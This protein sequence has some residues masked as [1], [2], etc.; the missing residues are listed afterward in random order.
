MKFKFI[1][2]VFLTAIANIFGQQNL[3]SQPNTPPLGAGGPYSVNDIINKI[4]SEVGIDWMKETR[5][6][7]IAGDPNTKVTGIATTFMSTLAVL[8][9][10][11]AMGCNFVI[12]HEPT[13]YTHTDDLKTHEKDPVQIAKLKF[14]NDNKMV[15]WRFHDHQHRMPSGDQIYQGVVEKMGW[16]KYATSDKTLLTIPPKSLAE[17]VKT[18]EKN[19]GAKTARIVGKPNMMVTKVGLALGA[20]G[21]GTHFNVM[22]TTSCELLIVGES[23][24]WETIPY[25]QDA[26]NLGLKRSIIVLGHADSEEAGMLTNR[27]WLRGFYPNLKIEFIEAGNPYWRN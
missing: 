1:L 22:E 13:F 8:K 7:V 24:E 27:N 21:T 25:I 17:I 12:T 6:N 20:A 18:L 10:A 14:I 4:K 19:M 15:V 9:K 16:K 2:F 3:S 11:K 26:I 5:D 23:N